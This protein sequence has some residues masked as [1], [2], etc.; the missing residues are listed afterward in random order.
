MK[1]LTL[2]WRAPRAALLPAAFYRRQWTLLAVLAALLY[3]VLG[4]GRLDHWLA[5]FSFD[6]L[7]QRFPWQHNW[8][9]EHVNHVWPK[10][11]ALL[12]GAVALGLGVLG[13]RFGVVDA[14]MARR[15]RL[16]F[17]AMALGSLSVSLLKQL[18]PYH[19][20]WDLLEFGG[21]APYVPLLAALPAGVPAGKCFPAGHASGGFVLMAV[22]FVYAD[23]R[24]GLARAWLCGGLALGVLMGVGQQ[25]RG[26][27]F[28]SH[29]L[30]SGWVVWA[31]LLGCQQSLARR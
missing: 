6:P 20:P 17:I 14:E 7:S 26:A 21:H 12:V 30:W 13:E 10:N 23:T 1:L 3:A 9:L 25:L 15:W 28:L 4:D 19:C 18:S 29:T 24:P 5:A 8:W 2:P 11:L 27:H 22:Y 16:A 31:V